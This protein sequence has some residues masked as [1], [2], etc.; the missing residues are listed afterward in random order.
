VRVESPVR[1]GKGAKIQNGGNSWRI[2]ACV[3]SNHIYASRGR[4][5]ASARRFIR[6]GGGAMSRKVSIL[7]CVWSAGGPGCAFWPGWVRGSPFPAPPACSPWSKTTI[8][9]AIG[10]QHG[11][12]RHSRGP[13]KVS[14][15]GSGCL[16]FDVRDRISA[17]NERI[18]ALSVARHIYAVTG[19]RLRRG[20]ATQSQY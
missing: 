6:N 20:G 2:L 12:A 4:R 15:G 3:G 1:S 11:G 17:G 8:R 13:A 18:L 10:G 7:V 14:R 5:S 9:D 19:M 16:L